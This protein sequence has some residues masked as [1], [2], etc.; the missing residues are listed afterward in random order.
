M[1]P[2]TVNML[3]FRSRM[4]PP[5]FAAARGARSQH[6]GMAYFISSSVNSAPLRVIA[7]PLS[8]R[9]EPWGRQCRGPSRVGRAVRR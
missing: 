2:N 5:G 9:H 1:T 4:R 6:G 8:C 7:C 3:C